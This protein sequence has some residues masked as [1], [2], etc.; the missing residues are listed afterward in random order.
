MTEAEWRASFDPCAM[1]GWLEELGYSEEHWDFAI[2]CC[3]RI[4]DEMPSGSVRRVAEHVAQIGTRDVDDLLGEASQA[5]ERLER[6]IR[7]VSDAGEQA[8]LNRQLGFGRMVL[9]F[10]QQDG[11]G[12]AHAISRDLLEWADE[13]DEERRI[14]AGLLRELVPAPSRQALANDKPD[15][16]L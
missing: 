16:S 1:I 7:K 10:E 5:L 9:A 14:Q 13:P 2:A 11:A 3:R 15:A 6:Q 12:A 4:A 8:R